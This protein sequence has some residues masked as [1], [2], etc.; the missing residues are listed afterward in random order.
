RVAAC[1]RNF[2]Y[3][4]SFYSLNDTIAF[5]T[6]SFEVEVGRRSVG[7]MGNLVSS[8]TLDS[9]SAALKSGAK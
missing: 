9:G 4:I 3:G 2:F 5:A 7:T 8:Q 6:T 1:A